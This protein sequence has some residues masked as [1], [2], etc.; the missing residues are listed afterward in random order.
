MLTYQ[1]DGW[2]ALGDPTRRAIFERVALRP[3]AVGELASELPVSRPAVSQHLKILKEAGLV[4]D[5]PA[6]N[7]R[8]YHADPDGIAALRA[9]LDRFWSQTLATFK[10]VVEQE[11]EEVE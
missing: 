2:A 8:I 7:R 1:G 3:R 10:E 4:L 6:G 11:T 9:E 5:R